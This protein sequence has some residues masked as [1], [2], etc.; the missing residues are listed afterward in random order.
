MALTDFFKINLPYGL[1][2]ND[3]GEWFVFN[4]EYMPLGWNKKDISNY[5]DF[6]E[7][8]LYTKYN[9]LTEATILNTIKDSERIQR[10]DKGEITQIF[11][12]YD[13]NDPM[14]DSTKWNDYF[15]K[16]EAF[17]QFK[18]AGMEY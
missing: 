4:R 8:P 5:N 16:I 14:G 2:R 7:L 13:G 3:A 11:F 10:N 12:Y 9:G 15:E 1:K 18:I 17:S 6:K